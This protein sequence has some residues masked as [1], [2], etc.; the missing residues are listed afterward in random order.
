MGVLWYGDGQFAGT[1]GVATDSSDYVYVSNSDTMSEIDTMEIQK[2]DSNGN[3][4][5]KWGSKGYGDGQFYLP[6]GIAVDS[7]DNVYVAEYGNNRIQKFD[8]NGNFT[9]KWGSTGNGDGQF[10]GPRGIAVDSS[11][12]RVC[13]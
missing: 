13:N 4:I 11:N 10:N 1:N 6:F 7:L 9:T 8:S 2:F 12:K 3:F 5:T